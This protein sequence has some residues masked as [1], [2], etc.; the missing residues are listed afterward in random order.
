MNEAAFRQSLAELAEIVLNVPTAPAA[1]S[2]AS[3]PV[4]GLYI[5]CNS[6]KTTVEQCFDHLRVLVK[7]VVFDLEATRRENRYL[8]QMLESRSQRDE[9][10]DDRSI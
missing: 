6:P 4:P 3:Q 5:A 9:D 1:P 7:Y 2:S 8:R 10:R